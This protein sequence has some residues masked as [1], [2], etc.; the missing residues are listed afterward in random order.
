MF[1]TSD[2]PTPIAFLLTIAVIIGMVAIIAA[3]VGRV[4]PRKGPPKTRLSSPWSVSRFV[5]R[6]GETAAVLQLFF[7]TIS[8]AVSGGTIGR[9]IAQSPMVGASPYQFQTFITTGAL[10]GGLFGLFMSSL[11]LALVFTLSE[12]E[13]NTR[14][15]AALFERMYAR[16]E[17]V[18]T[19]R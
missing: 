12:I 9:L 19:P 5:I 7:F 3:V 8:G 16:T 2:I 11:W 17:E 18:K 14:H 15:T 13:R 10:F 1:S 6:V 4:M